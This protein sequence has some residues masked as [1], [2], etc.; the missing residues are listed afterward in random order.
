MLLI[1][2]TGP[3]GAGKSTVSDV[4]RRYG[5]PVLDADKIYH[6]LLV[7]P[8][9]CLSELVLQFGS[10]ILNPDGTLNR[11]RLAELALPDPDRLRALN[12]IAHRHVLSDI[13]RRVRHL[14]SDGVPAAVLDAPQLFESGADRDC[15]VIVSVLC[16]RE[17]RLQR[18]LARD[19]LTAE[20][21]ERRFN[22]QHDDKFFRLRSDYI[23][24]ND[25]SAAYL[26]EQVLSILRE[27]G[28]YRP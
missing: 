6:D 17:L 1:G 26:E 27:T 15:S 13:R 28:A 7:P 25:R 24:E 18:I 20:Q 16:S 21:A 10:K 12:E 19:H 8:S 14:Q 9:D 11:P 5:L 23:I 2:L 22:A 4:F 3:S